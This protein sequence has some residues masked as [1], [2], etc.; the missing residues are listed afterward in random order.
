MRIL[1]STYIIKFYKCSDFLMT[2]SLSFRDLNSGE[3]FEKIS[4]NECP[5]VVETAPGWVHDITNIG[6][7]EM[8]VLAWA[9][10]NFDL[11]NPDTIPEV[12]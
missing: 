7:D 6:S 1:T 10:E 8:I 9:N 4:S 5:E 11:K 2:F 3:I 12:V